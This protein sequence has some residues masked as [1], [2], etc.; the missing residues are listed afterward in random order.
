MVYKGPGIA[1]D[2]ARV[3]KDK[4][5]ATRFSNLAEAVGSSA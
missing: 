4:L 5:A 3:L 2:M 1:R